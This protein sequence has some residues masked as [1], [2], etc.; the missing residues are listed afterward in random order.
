[1]FDILLLAISIVSIIALAKLFTEGGE[2][3]WKAL[4]PY[5]N[6]YIMCKIAHN[7]LFKKYLITSIIF[8]VLYSLNSY[9]IF[10]LVAGEMPS[11]LL[12]SMIIAFAL[13]GLSIYMLVLQY[14]ICASFAEAFGYSRGFG[15]GLLFLFPIFICI[16]GFSKHTKNPLS[17]TKPKN[18]YDPYKF[19]QDVDTENTELTEDN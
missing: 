15:F 17:Y 13:F 11:L 4:I 10:S 12:L 16:M 6:I 9:T 7:N 3:W 18:T 1:M 19:E 14:K 8:V 5:Y 2:A